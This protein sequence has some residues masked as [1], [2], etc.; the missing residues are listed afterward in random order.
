MKNKKRSVLKS[1]LASYSAATGAF[2]AVGAV[3]HGQVVYTDENPDAYYTGIG[4]NYHDIDFDGDG[5]P[6]FTLNQ[7]YHVYSSTYT[8]TSGG[9][10]T[11][12]NTWNYVGITKGVSSFGIIGTNSYQ[13]EPLSNNDVISVGASFNV[14]GFTWNI[15]SNGWNDFEGA[16][17]KY[18]GVRFS[19]AGEVHY[20][21]ILINVDANSVGLTVKDYGYESQPNVG[22]HAGDIIGVYTDDIIVDNIT[23]V[24]A[25][26]N[27]TPSVTGTEYFVVQPIGDTEP[28]A[29]EVM[30]GAGGSGATVADF[31][32]KA[33][34][35]G[36]ADIFNLD[37]LTINTNYAIYMVIV[38]PSNV[39]S[40]VDSVEFTTA[41]GVGIDY[42]GISEFNIFPVPATDVLNLELP[43]A[44]FVSVLD[45]MGKEVI[46]VETEAGRSTLDIS[47]LQAGVYVIQFESNGL[48]SQI[49]FTKE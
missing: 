3:A 6:E 37:G 33:V 35:A 24:T 17:D 34:T 13:C 29:A 12:H 1:K 9:T 46:K 49:K 23:T 43:S 31:G 18:V 38:D 8:T 21:W 14:N 28:T 30:S 2:L 7:S 42:N 26:A 44:A 27:F 47:Y 45:L 48:V 4:P 22:V 41:D 39:T 19:I 20:G 15:G 16:G 10:Y 25:D 36:T 40:G 11:Y 32:N 5:T